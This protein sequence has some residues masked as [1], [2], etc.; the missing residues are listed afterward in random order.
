MLIQLQGI[1]VASY[2]VNVI[3][4]HI[5]YAYDTVKATVIKYTVSQISRRF[6]SMREGG[7]FFYFLV[8]YLNGRGHFSGTI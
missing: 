1:N 2:C 6:L 3:D 4:M 8:T 5:C 7:V